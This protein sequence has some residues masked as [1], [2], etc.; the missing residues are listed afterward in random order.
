MTCRSPWT[1]PSIMERVMS[2]YLLARISDAHQ[3]NSAA[4]S[5]QTP[6]RGV[7]DGP[8]QVSAVKI[9]THISQSRAGKCI[10]WCHSRLPRVGR[11]C[12]SPQSA[13]LTTPW[14]LNRCSYTQAQCYRT[15]ERAQ[16]PA[17]RGPGPRLCDVGSCGR[18][19]EFRAQ[20]H[21]REN[22]LFWASSHR[23]SAPRPAPPGL[24]WD[25]VRMK[26]CA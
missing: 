25:H 12:T 6:R 3:V 19:T 13:L 7:I 5:V 10:T 21:D 8:P 17:R 15:S 16:G 22:P 18:M 11:P 23:V 26:S 2:L 1:P 4:V 24:N 9:I 14:P 20:V